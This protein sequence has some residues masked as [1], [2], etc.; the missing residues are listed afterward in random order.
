LTNDKI[1]VETVAKFTDENCT[2]TIMQ[3]IKEEPEKRKKYYN[4]LAKATFRQHLKP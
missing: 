3:P 1:E 4:A 2:F